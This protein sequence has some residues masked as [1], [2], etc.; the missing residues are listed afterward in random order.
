MCANEMQALTICWLCVFECVSLIY[1]CDDDADESFQFFLH[2][3]LHPTNEKE[4]S[5]LKRIIFYLYNEFFHMLNYLIVCTCLHLNLCSWEYSISKEP[6]L[7]SHSTSVLCIIETSLNKQ[8]QQQNKVK[9]T[10]CFD[11]Q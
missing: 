9:T 8:C 11:M 2:S 10:N 6:F 3:V 7:L 5:I 1:Y 4:N